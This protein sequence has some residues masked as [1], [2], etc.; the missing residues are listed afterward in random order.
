[1]PVHLANSVLGRFVGSIDSLRMATGSLAEGV[2]S[3]L[4]LGSQFGI[5]DSV[6][7]ENL[8]NP[9]RAETWGPQIIG[10]GIGAAAAIVAAIIVLGRQ[11]RHEIGRASCRERVSYHV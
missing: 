4:A 10:S 8:H 11:I 5:A 6:W 2:D 9:T 3:A 1:M 7:V